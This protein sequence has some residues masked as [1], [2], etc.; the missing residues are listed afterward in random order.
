MKKVFVLFEHTAFLT[1][2]LLPFPNFMLTICS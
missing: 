2:P 1:F